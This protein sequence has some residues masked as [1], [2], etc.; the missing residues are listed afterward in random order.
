M[1]NGDY[2]S[3]DELREDIKPL[4][5]IRERIDDFAQSEGLEAIWYFKGWP[6]V[7][8]G[9]SNKLQRRMHCG[10]RYGG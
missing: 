7:K 10:F 8:L 3:P 1:A 5:L 6:Y 2:F 4:E 9:W